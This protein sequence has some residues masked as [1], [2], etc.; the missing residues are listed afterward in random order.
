[1]HFK[2]IIQLQFLINREH[3]VQMDI[4]V[5]VYWVVRGLKLMEEIFYLVKKEDN[6]DE[7]C[8]L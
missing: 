8:V 3:T 4:H 1:M 5:H 7:R 2:F 6:D